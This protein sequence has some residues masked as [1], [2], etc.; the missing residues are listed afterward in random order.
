MT[1]RIDLY[2]KGQR[3]SDTYFDR[4]ELAA[5]AE[6]GASAQEIYDFAEDAVNHGEPDFATALLI[7]SAR[8]DY[9]MTIQ[10]GVKS[11]QVT[12]ADQLPAK[13]DQL[14]GV[15]WLPRIIE[16]ARLKLRG[17]MAQ[18]IMYCCGGDRRFLNSHRIHPADFL[19]VVWAAGE[20]KAKILNY[21][22]KSK[23]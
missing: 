15:E 11:E 23:G 19:R 3:G 17:E 14:E 21:V 18:E 20:D 2:K 13:T 6:M 9:F 4:E 22:L 5:L 10:K 12:S 7:T 1:K 8:R 16:K